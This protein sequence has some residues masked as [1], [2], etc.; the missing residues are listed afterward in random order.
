MKEGQE[1]HMKESNYVRFKIQNLVAASIAALLLWITAGCGGSG[2]PVAPDYSQSSTQRHSTID[3]VHTIFAY[4]LISV[5][6]NLDRVELI[7]V[8]AAAD[9]YNVRQFLEEGPCFD[10]VT[11]ANFQP[12][13]DGIISMDIQLAH[14]FVGLN[15]FTGFDVRGIVMFNGSEHWP[16]T[17]VNVPDSELGDGQ[18]LNADGYTR[19]FNPVEFPPGS[20]GLPIWE[21]SKGVLAPEAELNSI[22]NA[23]VAFEKDNPRRY[24]G[25]TDLASAEFVIK[26]P[27]GPFVFGYAVDA[28][29]APPDPALYG[30][31]SVIDVPEDFVISTNCPEAYSLSTS[32][33]FGLT[34]DGTGTAEVHVD[35]YD[36]QGDAISAGVQIECPGILTGLVNLD[37]EFSGPDFDRFSVEINN[38]LLAVQG[39]YRYLVEARDWTDDLSPMPHVSYQFG[40]MS[41]VHYEP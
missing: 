36:W 1:I 19:L 12:Q 6:E 14:P 16:E 13:P 27:G 5:S 8:R 21:Y 40:T 9:H 28:C 39:W 37:Y 32:A 2:G 29:W 10:C 23:Y 34:D 41:V 7:P 35:V 17:G 15:Q 24:F 3:S 31:P 20:M 33:T 26:K 38:D 30:D 25:T 18:L 4:G 11:I 22:L